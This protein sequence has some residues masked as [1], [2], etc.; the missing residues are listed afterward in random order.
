MADAG[1]AIYTEGWNE[2]K[3]KWR[4][5]T[6]VNGARRKEYNTVTFV[7]IDMV[8][9]RL[10]CTAITDIAPPSRAEC[11]TIWKQIHNLSRI[12]KIYG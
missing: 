1:N 4:H 3:Q 10:A 8:T 9:S 2:E 7:A 5:A 6:R 11:R 12:Y